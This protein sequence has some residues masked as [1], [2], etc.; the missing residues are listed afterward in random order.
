ML[1]PAFDILEMFGIE[2]GIVGTDSDVVD[3]QIHAQPPIAAVERWRFALHLDVQVASLSTDDELSVL[4]LPCY[5]LSIVLGQD[6]AALHS[7]KHRADGA[8]SCLEEDA[9]SALVIASGTERSLANLVLEL[10]P[11]EHVARLVPGCLYQCGRK[12]WQVCSNASV[13]RSMQ[14]GLV[15]LSVFVSPIKNA[16]TRLIEHNDCLNEVIC[17]LQAYLDGA[18]HLI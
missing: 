10:I 17:A 4:H 1:V 14:L 7:T 6:K 15:V 9:Q 11:L 12:R 13:C 8:V 18:K 5:V 2:E 16:L 3:S